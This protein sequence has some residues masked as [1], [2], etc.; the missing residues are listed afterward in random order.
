MAQ[1]EVQAGPFRLVSLMT[2]EAA[3]ELGLTRGMVA[4]AVVKATYVT[5]SACEDLDL[6]PGTR[7]TVVIKTTAVHLVARGQ[8]RS[9]GYID[10]ASGCEAGLSG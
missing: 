5:R 4:T 9:P 6:R 10:K 2:R 7:V 1:V 3:D 8:P